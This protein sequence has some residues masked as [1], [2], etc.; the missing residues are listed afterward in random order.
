VSLPRA[1][2]AEVVVGAK[3]ANPILS[4]KIKVETRVVSTGM[5]SGLHRLHQ[6]FS[7]AGPTREICLG[8]TTEMGT[9]SP[10]TAHLER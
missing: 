5:S 6:L 1:S 4:H 2:P 8:R 7:A 10:Q 3:P 9:T